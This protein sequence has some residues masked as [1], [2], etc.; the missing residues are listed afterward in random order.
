MR[1][2]I[3]S[4]GTE[5]LMGQITDTNAAFLSS[6]LPSLGIGLY[7]VTQVGDNQGRIVEALERG[8]GRSDIILTTGGL[9]PTEDD[10]TRESIAKFM[11]EEMYR[12]PELLIWLQG[13]M[14][15]NF[16]NT[17][18]QMT[19]NNFKQ[20]NLIPS[21]KAIPNDRGTAPGW[22]VEKN[23]KMIISMPGPPSE[24][25]NMWQRHVRPMLAQKFPGDIL[26]SRFIK[27]YG[28]GESA[29]DAMIEEYLHSNNPS[30]GVYTRP[31]GIMMRL[32]AKAPDEAAGREIL[33]PVEAGIQRIL[34][35]YVWGFDDDTIVSVVG[36]ELKAKGMTLATMESCTGGLLASHIT[37]TAGSS[38]FFKG[39][40]VTY[41]NEIKTSFGVDPS[42][43]ETKGAISPETAEA[44]AKAVRLRLHS[45]IGIGI[46]GVA[47]PDP[48]EGK[49]VGEVHLAISDGI[50]SA[51]FMGKYRPP[52]ADLKS[53]A[54]YAALFNLR[55]FLKQS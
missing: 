43:I 47:G 17:N 31:D 29:L 18:R 13:V 48:I 22:M 12:D 6:Q 37:D 45:S 35:D 44:M 2:E 20:A 14:Q 16:R 11:G 34:Q 15:N 7:W 23:G 28:L 24:M 55:A 50:R 19:S 10:L 32:T 25:T 9:G 53:R 51:T 1:A 36:K 30:I 21:A 5:L 52:R 39:G 49:P 26:V 46:T 8:L 4:I 40:L 33:A 38:D 42:I 3:I 41:T 54:A 27:A